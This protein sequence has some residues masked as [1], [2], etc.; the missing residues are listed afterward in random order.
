MAVEPP[1]VPPTVVGQVAA[2]LKFVHGLG[3]SEMALSDAEADALAQ[4]VTGVARY[5]IKLTVSNKGAA[6]LSLIVTCG[7]IYGPR[8]S[9]INER[10]AKAKAARAAKTEP[11]ISSIDIM[12]PQ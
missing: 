7:M 11:S 1:E 10:N 5:Y 2:A 9:A 4:A 6:W 8:I 3:P 12:L